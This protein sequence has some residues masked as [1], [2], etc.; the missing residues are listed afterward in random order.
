[1]P[2]L[3]QPGQKVLFIGDSITDSG[4]RDSKDAPL[5]NGYVRLCADLV[6][7]RYPDHRNTFVNTGIGGH[8]ARNLFD[9]W[10]DDAIAHQ[11]DWL[12]VMIGINDI[13]Q[14][15]SDNPT[16]VNP[17][18][19]A[20]YYDRILHRAKA[21]AKARLILVQPFYVTTERP[22]VTLG[23]RGRVMAHL[24]EYLRTVEE[25]ARKYDAILVRTHDAFQR[26]LK[27]T[28][29]DALAPDSVHLTP[30]GVAVLAHEWLA[31][32]GW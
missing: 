18:Q 24:P 16:G 9:R 28:R 26:Q 3:I 5:G 2:F 25:M 20:D 6:A 15:L 7:A 11:P 4:R 30:S 22:D 14:W 8:N 29:A 17:T 21:E 32:V 31:A 23:W 12:S 10:H 19:Y 13:S 27:H 1:M